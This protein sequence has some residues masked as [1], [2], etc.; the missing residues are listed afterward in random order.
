M[1]V[2]TIATES[3]LDK[4]VL[5]PGKEVHIKEKNVLLGWL[6]AAV[7][8]YLD[9][10]LYSVADMIL[11][12]DNSKNKI[13]DSNL[14]GKEIKKFKASKKGSEFNKYLSFMMLILMIKVISSCLCWSNT[15]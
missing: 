9:P 14:D 6:I 3:Y 4:I 2:V 15:L 8:R 13:F 5:H 11:N 12:W 10:E 1:L 7:M